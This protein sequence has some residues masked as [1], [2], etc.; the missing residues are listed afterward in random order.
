MTFLT[1]T[2]DVSRLRH[3]DVDMSVD[4]IY[5]TGLAGETFFKA[6]RDEGRILAV[7]CPVCKVS[8][9]PPRM[10]C[11]GCFTELHDFVEVPTQGRVAAFTVAH[12]D[13]RGQPLPSPEVFAFVTFKG[14]QEGGLI[15][16]LLVPPE[17]ARV[18]LQVRVKLKPKELRTGS[19]R[20]IE[21]FEPS[22]S[23][24]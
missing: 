2:R 21:G 14:I 5:T 12:A 13:R 17:K 22:T 10:F 4:Y 3:V 15:H 7:H 18:G 23:Q 9:L 19:I 8:Q 6:L 24:P 11:E 16:R 20:D 1:R